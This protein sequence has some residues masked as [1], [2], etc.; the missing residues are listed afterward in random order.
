[1]P[2]DRFR[3]TVTARISRPWIWLAIIALR[4]HLE[5][6]SHWLVRRSVSIRTP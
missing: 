6:L 5:T 2:R 3:L 4:L 1:M